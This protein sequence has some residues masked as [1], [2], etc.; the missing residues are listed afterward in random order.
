[1]TIVTTGSPQGDKYAMTASSFMSVSL[2]PPTVLVCINKRASIS[3]PLLA[4]RHLCINVLGAR[5]RKL[6]VQCAGGHSRDR[7]AEAD[8]HVDEAGLPYLKD[9][10]AVLACKVQ[11]V[12]DGG[13]HHVILSQVVRATAG[14][15]IDPLEYLDG[16]FVQFRHEQNRDST[17]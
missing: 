9:A 10:Q 8:W 4:S 15:A 11:Q 17:L 5:H 6:A 1:M 12:V 3:A 16:S 7:F 2:E 14:P 13:S